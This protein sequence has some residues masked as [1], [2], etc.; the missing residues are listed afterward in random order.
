MLAAD[1]AQGESG[2]RETWDEMAEER[3]L[4]CRWFCGNWSRQ[5][6]GQ[7]RCIYA[8]EQMR[9]VVCNA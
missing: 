8:T 3:V 4:K 9:L 6:S 2:S 5:R 1:S 7:Y